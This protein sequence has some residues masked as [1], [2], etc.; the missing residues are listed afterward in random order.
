MPPPRAD[1]D[2]IVKSL[3]FKGKL[4]ARPYLFLVSGANRLNERKVARCIGEAIVRPDAD[5]VRAATVFAV[6]DISPFGHSQPIVPYFDS[7]PLAF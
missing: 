1:V 6:G 4:R 2:Q 3:I 7:D 5:F